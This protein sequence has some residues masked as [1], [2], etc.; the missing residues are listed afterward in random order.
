MSFA[1]LIIIL[2]AAASLPLPAQEVHKSVDAEGNV[3]Y[4][5]APV[6]GAVETGTVRIDPPVS[7]PEREA[8]SRQRAAEMIDAAAADQQ[9]R[10]AESRQ[11]RTGRQAAEQS[12]RDA[13]ARLEEA[14]VVREGDRRGTAGGSSR[15]T[16][17]YLDRV[18]AAEQDAERA[19]REL[20]KTR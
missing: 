1:R 6:A 11:R 9:R 13:E 4:S 14:R 15:L 20:E 3:T 18:R 10:D 7:T 2:L 8:E 16:P 17:E 12:L 19:R 5:D